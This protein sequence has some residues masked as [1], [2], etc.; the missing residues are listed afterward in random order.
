MKFRLLLIFISV[1]LIGCRTPQKSLEK[2]N[3]DRA[4]KLALSKL[5]H[6]K[7]VEE[8]KE[9]L[10]AALDEIIKQ[11]TI[12]IKKLKSFGTLEKALKEVQN[13]QVKIN[14]TDYYLLEEISDKKDQFEQEEQYLKSEISKNFMQDGLEN[15]TIAENDMDKEK[16]KKAYYSFKKVKKYN[17]NIPKIDSLLQKSHQLGQK[18]YIVKA[19][20]TFDILYN[21]K[22]DH[23]F[24]NLENLGGKF[25]K[26]Y[27]EPIGEKTG[28]DCTIDVKF[29]SLCISESE[30]KNKRMF[31]KTIVTG[32]E[33]V[34]NSDGQTVKVEKTE[35][36][37]GEFI[38]KKITKTADWV[39][40]VNINAGTKNCSLFNRSF[41]EDV[42]DVIE[43]YILEGDER[44]VPNCYKS[45]NSND[46]LMSDD[47]MADE[48]IE[49]LYSQIRSYIL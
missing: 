1:G 12:E 48:L 11:K 17:S 10:S 22:I 14:A 13:L 49:E 21:W 44:A 27:F 24:D 3:Y 28:T 46:K 19:N 35:E 16:A 20:A 26:V 47:D 37:S 23:Q 42:E 32:K 30:T 15:L 8:N 41:S 25:I 43:E 45:K 29:G 2:K 39:A 9:I 38:T 5:K 40:Q 7:A 31:T 36:V 6:N 18:T 4:F 33:A 34:I